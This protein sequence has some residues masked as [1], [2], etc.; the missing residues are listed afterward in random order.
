M[1]LSIGVLLA[2]SFSAPPAFARQGAS[3]PDAQGRCQN[4]ETRRRRGNLFGNLAGRALGR[5]GV[6]SSVAGLSLPTEQLLSEAIIAVLDCQERQQ[7]AR[8]TE[9]AVRSGTVGS[10][11]TWQSETRP[12]VSGSST[13]TGQSAAADGA[14]CLTVTDLIIVEG[15]EQRV[16]KTMCRRPPSNRYARV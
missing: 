14:Q 1:I 6:P 5:A 7:A 3:Q 13:V 2:T 12:G 9:E 8:A 4:Q 15:Q 11:S 10:T 16:P